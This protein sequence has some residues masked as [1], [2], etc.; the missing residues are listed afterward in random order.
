MP[1]TAR[2]SCAA[3]GDTLVERAVITDDG[4]FAN[5][6]AHTVVNEY[7]LANCRAG[8]NL[9]PGQESPEVAHK[10]GEEE[11]LHFIEPVCKS[12]ELD[13]VTSRVGEHDL[14]PRT[15]RRIATLNRP[16]FISNCHVMLLDRSGPPSLGPLNGCLPILTRA[17]DS[18]A[19]STGAGL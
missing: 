5:D 2:L 11:E 17:L 15:R 7:A 4:R 12:M 10:P 14:E 6:D 16:D 1:L 19:P 13:R 18:G 3:Q 9:D 8:M